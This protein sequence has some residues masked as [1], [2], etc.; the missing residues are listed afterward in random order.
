MKP[1]QGEE[2]VEGRS[3]HKA[4]QRWKTPKGIGALV[5][6]APWMGAVALCDSRLGRWREESLKQLW[7]RLRDL[8]SKRV[9]RRAIEDNSLY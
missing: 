2:T 5:K 8:A 4:F 3:L 9:R 1:A 6:E 7:V